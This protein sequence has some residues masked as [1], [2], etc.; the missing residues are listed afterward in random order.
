MMTAAV[1]AA[2]MLGEATGR[3]DTTI[4]LVLA[5][6]G[7]ISASNLTAP[8]P[9]RLIAT[10]KHHAAEKAA[11]DQ[12]ACGPPPPGLDPIRA[13]AHRLRTED[14]INA[15][16]RR[17]ATVEP[18]IGSLKDRIGLR[19]FARRGTSAAASELHLAA[20]VHNLL[21]WRHAALA[22]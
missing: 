17:G 6:A 18:A 4:D 1:E 5:D 14:G 15:Y 8:G 21:K 2:A 9:D 7:Y 3:T 12:P 13:M 11:R 22:T 19:R 10:G 16:R 20:T